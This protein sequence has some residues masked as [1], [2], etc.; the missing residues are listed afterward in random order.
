MVPDTLQNG[1][2]TIFGGIHGA[3]LWM[4]SF[5]NDLAFKIFTSGNR[6][7]FSCSQGRQDLVFTASCPIKYRGQYPKNTSKIEVMIFMSNRVG[8]GLVEITKIYS[9][10]D[11]LGVTNFQI[12][13]LLIFPGTTLVAFSNLVLSDPDGRA[14]KI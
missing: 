10:T 11:L 12:F 5:V 9:D 13:P 14:G 8:E 3:P 6:R 7:S 1:T 4:V 2:L